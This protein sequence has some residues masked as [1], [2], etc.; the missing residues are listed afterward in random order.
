MH[1]RLSN[2][3]TSKTRLLKGISRDFTNYVQHRAEANVC[4]DLELVKFEQKSRPKKRDV[5][6][7]IKH[8]TK[9]TYRKRSGRSYNKQMRMN[10]MTKRKRGVYVYMCGMEQGNC[11]SVGNQTT[12]PDF[13]SKRKTIMKIRPYNIQKISFVKIE[14]FIEKK[15]QQEN[16]WSCKRSPE[17]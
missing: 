4:R 13:W 16:Q 15:Q 8:C 1:G 11:R 14:N 6:R 2:Y 12:L 3:Q 17:T 10:T 7:Q 9:R 5:E